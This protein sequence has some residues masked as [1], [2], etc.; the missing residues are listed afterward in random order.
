M[1]HK[2]ETL[3]RVNQAQLPKVVTKIENVI[4]NV[5]KKQLKR[6]WSK[7]VRLIAI[8]VPLQPTP[9]TYGKHTLIS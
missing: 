9:D 6:F 2:K 3:D 1:K 4:S 8:M 5:P 7:G